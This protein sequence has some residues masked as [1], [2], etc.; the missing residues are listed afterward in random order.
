MNKEI[1]KMGQKVSL[2]FHLFFMQCIQKFT[3]LRKKSPKPLN[4]GDFF[5]IFTFSS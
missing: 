1:K 3:V 5:L 4:P 2:S